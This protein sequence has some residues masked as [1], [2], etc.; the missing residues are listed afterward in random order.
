MTNTLYSL[1]GINNYTNFDEY[2]NYLQINFNTYIFSYFLLRNHKQLIINTMI[3]IRL[4]KSRNTITIMSKDDNSCEFSP[5]IRSF[6][7]ELE[8]G[9]TIVDS[10]ALLIS[11]VDVN[12]NDG[13]ISFT[14]DDVTS[15][16]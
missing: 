7:G 1:L 13:I 2:G 11:I 3:V 15:L 5:Q 8:V 12:I 6:D 4:V 16:T 9:F 14:V 10:I